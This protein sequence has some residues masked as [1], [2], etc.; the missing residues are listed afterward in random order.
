MRRGPVLALALSPHSS[1]ADAGVFDRARDL[2]HLLGASR[3]VLQRARD[4]VAGQLCASP[5]RGAGRAATRAPCP[6]RR[7]GG[8]PAGTSASSA[9]M[10]LI[11]MLRH[12]FAADASPIVGGEGVG[13]REAQVRCSDRQ[14]A[15][16]MRTAE[17]HRRRHPLRTDRRHHGRLDV[18]AAAGLDERRSRPSGVVGETEFRSRSMACP[19]SDAARQPRPRR[20][21]RRGHGADD[22]VAPATASAGP[23]AARTR[24]AAIARAGT[25]PGVAN[26]RSQAA[27]RHG[28]RVRG[29]PR[30]ASGRPR[31]S[32]AGRSD[33]ARSCRAP[34]ASRDVIPRRAS[35][36]ARC[37]AAPSGAPPPQVRR[38]ATSISTVKKPVG[39]STS[40]RD[41]GSAG[42]S[43]G[44]AGGDRTGQHA[45]RC[46][47]D[48]AE[49]ADGLVDAMRDEIART[50]RAARTR[51]GDTGHLRHGLRAHVAQVH[52]RA[53]SRAGCAR[54]GP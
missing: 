3:A 15:G 21:I 47:A 40:S 54:S 10:P 13:A 9:S 18:T 4:H 20:R 1:G 23:V 39:C 17:Q 8:R 16:G 37:A 26:N 49:H 31:R 48:G 51:R 6:R 29:D 7:S 50:D 30:P 38:P 12:I 27:D 43:D 35:A 46:D 11:M 33:A 53:E 36:C 22:Q 42:G 28:C 32:R 34:Q 19:V 25:L 52:A 41:C 2:A 44:H 24:D 45:R 14:Q 5:G